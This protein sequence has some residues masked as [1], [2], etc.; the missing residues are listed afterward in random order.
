MICLVITMPTTFW[1]YAN[2]NRYGL[3]TECTG[4][5]NKNLIK[6]TMVEKDTQPPKFTC[7]LNNQGTI[8]YDT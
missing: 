8:G 5:K 4:L 6:S 3:W 7:S 2:G 1:F